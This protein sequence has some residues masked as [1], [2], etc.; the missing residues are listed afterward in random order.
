M[1]SLAKTGSNFKPQS[2]LSSDRSPI[3]TNPQL[4]DKL[5]LLAYEAMKSAGRH[6]VLRAIQR[7]IS[8]SVFSISLMSP[9]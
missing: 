5:N 3:K 7:E 8:S 4:S 6:F 9:A 1:T 2:V